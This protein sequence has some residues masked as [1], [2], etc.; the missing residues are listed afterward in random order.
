MRH[1][2]G[3][4][5]YESWLR[6]CVFHDPAEQ[7]SMEKEKQA[8]KIFFGATHPV[9][10]GIKIKSVVGHHQT[11]YRKSKRHQRHNVDLLRFICRKDLHSRDA[12]R[13]R[14]KRNLN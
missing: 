5:A 1:F 4:A 2:K 9:V 10:L 13:D 11:A 7:K 12:L 8:L 3:L 6:R 14:K